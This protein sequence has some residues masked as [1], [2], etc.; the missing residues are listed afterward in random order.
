MRT[1]VT[2]LSSPRPCVP[3]LDARARVV[4]LKT[5]PCLA[6]PALHLQQASHEPELVQEWTV[7]GLWVLG[8]V[9]DTVGCAEWVAGGC[10][11]GLWWVCLGRWLSDSF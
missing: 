9:P 10:A 1:S 7:P 8:P 6:S 4:W 2:R 5:T 11:A 3:V